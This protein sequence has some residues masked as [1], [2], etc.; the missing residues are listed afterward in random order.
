M[1]ADGVVTE[2][3]RIVRT[4][5]LL[6]PGS[7]DA[8]GPS[9]RD[10][11]EAPM[12]APELVRASG[13]LA[14]SLPD[15]L[16]P[17]RVDFL[18]GQLV[19]CEWTARRL[20]GQ[21]VPFAREV[22]EVFGVRIRM[23]SED[24][25]RGAHRELEEL[26]PGPGPLAE[27]VAAHRR[28]EEVPRDRLVAVVRALSGALRE[29][30]VAKVDL[31]AGEHVGH[32]LVDSAPWSALHHYRGGYASTVTFNA[33]ARLRCSQLAQI[34]AHE[35]YPGH[36][37]ER[38]RKEVGLVARGWGEH[39]VVVVTSPQSLVAE[40]AADLGLRAVVGPGWGPWAAEV[41]ADVGCAFDGE[42]AERV[43]TATSALTRAR[44]DAAVLLHGHRASEAEVLDHLCRWLLVGQERAAAVLGFLRHPLW[45][46]YTTTYVEGPELLHRWWEAGS[47]A[48][49][50][51]RILD[52][53]LTPWTLRAESAQVPVAPAG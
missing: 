40:G 21:P 9:F 23:G 36:H 33:G 4:L 30:T 53:P 3:L 37:T 41:L 13:R 34:V 1:R 22:Q 24:A 49:R 25:Y 10:A 15:R 20:V 14:R 29:R 17:A 32:R 51:V 43:D 16:D 2:Y 42:L 26:L 27:R 11:A 5:A 35:I 19:A 7:V 31:P 6:L 18:R 28:R 44:L 52:E 47:S 46:A 45:R 48:D 8:F 12:T 38:C 39:R 50:L